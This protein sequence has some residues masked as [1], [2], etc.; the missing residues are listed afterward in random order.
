MIITC[1]LYRLSDPPLL[2]VNL[3]LANHRDKICKRAIFCGCFDTPHF[4]LL[5][6]QQRNTTMKFCKNLQ[7][8]AG[9]SDP[10]WAP[11]WPNY[12]MLKVRLTMTMTLSMSVFIFVVTVLWQRFVLLRWCLGM[13]TGLLK[14]PHESSTMMKKQFVFLTLLHWPYPFQQTTTT[15]TETHQGVTVFGAIWWRKA[16]VDFPQPAATRR[17]VSGKGRFSLFPWVG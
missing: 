15:T 3:V 11:Y 2:L 16:N 9:I 12:K 17:F 14:K 4:N 10:E 1:K 6:T 5:R 13:Y 7:R 8:V